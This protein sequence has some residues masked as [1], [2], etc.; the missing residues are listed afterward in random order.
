MSA[1]FV[2]IQ[3]FKTFLFNYG[4]ISHVYVQYKI[5]VNISGKNKRHNNTSQKK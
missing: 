3:N 4:E 1:D 2:Y 5:V